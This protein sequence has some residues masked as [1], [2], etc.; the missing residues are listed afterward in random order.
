MSN[1]R[2]QQ[3]VGYSMVE[4]LVMVSVL[5]TVMTVT[6]SWI[7]A[8]MKFSKVVKERTAVH[9]Q[10]D[11]LSTELRSRI[12][13]S[14]SIEV[15]GNTLKVNSDGVTTRY[16]IEDRVIA[17]ERKSNSEGDESS[18]NFETFHIGPNV[19]ARWG[20]EELPEW[21]SLTIRQKPIT[22]IKG[23]AA[24]S[25][26]SLE[27]PKLELYLRTGPRDPENERQLNE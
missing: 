12:A 18:V 16:N 22:P 3:R 17:R 7:H 24:A 20:D 13:I 6:L 19:E 10:L 26:G 2:Y 25:I 8:S 11:R 4:M 15:D 1:K 23:D 27:T 9:Q 5:T 14:D 21:V